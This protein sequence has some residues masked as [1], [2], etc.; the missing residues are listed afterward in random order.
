MAMT[1]SPAEAKTQQ[2]RVLAALRLGYT[3]CCLRCHL[4]TLLAALLLAAVNVLLCRALEPWCSQPRAHKRKTQGSQAYN[5]RRGRAP[6]SHLHTLQLLP[7]RC[8]PV[9]MP[10]LSAGDPLIALSTSRCLLTGSLA[11]SS[12]TPCSSP[13]LLTRKS[14]YSLHAR[15]SAGASTVAVMKASAY[16]AEHVQAGVQCSAVHLRLVKRQTVSSVSATLSAAP[17]ACRSNHLHTSATHA[18]RKTRCETAV[19]V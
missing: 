5:R 16:S 7:K 2:V 18:H 15:Q 10:A 1:S 3:C 6:C 12:P 8:A 17:C 9:V 13:S 11:I 4:T 19:A 14:A